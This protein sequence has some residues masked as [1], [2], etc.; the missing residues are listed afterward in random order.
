MTGGPTMAMA[1]SVLTTGMNRLA[2]GVTDRQ[3]RPVYGPTSLTL[4]HFGAHANQ[5]ALEQDLR[6]YALDG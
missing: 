2:F 4:T 5:A 6:R 3:G 1:S